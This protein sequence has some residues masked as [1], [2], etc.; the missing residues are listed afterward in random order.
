MF[1]RSLAPLIAAAVIAGA[2]AL[3]ARAQSEPEDQTATT[4]QLALNAVEAAPA[5]ER[6]T[7]RLTLE[8]GR[9]DR[10]ESATSRSV[11]A[12]ALAAHDIV[13]TGADGAPAPF[14]VREMGTPSG[15]ELTLIIEHF[16]PAP[17][18]AGDRFT[19][20]ILEEDMVAADRASAEFDFLPPALESVGG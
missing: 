2:A 6:G 5:E 12:P 7:W 17:F 4:A 16:G 9:A 18:A 10:T 3:P 11:H 15:N 14:I 13:I 1:I 20:S 8:F 19:V